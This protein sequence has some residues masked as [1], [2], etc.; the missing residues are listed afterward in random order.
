MPFAVVTSV[1]NIQAKHKG[2]V[3][4]LWETIKEF[5]L[6]KMFFFAILSPVSDA[7]LEAHSGANFLSNGVIERWNQAALGYFDLQLDKAYEEVEIIL[8][9]K[10]V[11]Y[12]NVVLFVQRF[13]SLVIFQVAVVIKANIAIFL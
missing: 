10:N 12:K 3:L 2:K 6:L 7:T 13:Q 9:E 4:S 1:V 11:Y 5:L 8:V